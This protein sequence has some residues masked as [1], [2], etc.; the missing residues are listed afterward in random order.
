MPTFFL[1][2]FELPLKALLPSLIVPI[3]VEGTAEHIA[4]RCEARCGRLGRDGGRH[5]PRLP[6]EE[7]HPRTAVESRVTVLQDARGTR[8][9]GYE[10]WLPGS[11][12]LVV[13]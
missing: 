1:L 10:S 12:V 6:G 5:V 9:D 8:A 2:H 4:G 3:L 11:S 7:L 13:V